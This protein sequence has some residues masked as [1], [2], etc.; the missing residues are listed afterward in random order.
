MALVLDGL[1]LFVIA[2][3]ASWP[4]EDGELAVVIFVDPDLGPDVVV[5]VLVLGDLQ[6]QA[7]VAHGV[8]VGDAAL[9]LDR[10]DVGQAGPGPGKG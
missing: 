1:S 7:L 3:Q 6:D 4:V 2:G 8:V 5:A 9:L 10:E